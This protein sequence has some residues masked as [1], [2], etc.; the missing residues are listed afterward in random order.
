MPVLLSNT[1]PEINCS[2]FPSVQ[3]HFWLEFPELSI[4]L[5]ACSLE[6]RSL[7]VLVNLTKL[8]LV[9]HECKYWELLA[10]LLLRAPNLEV[11]ALEDV[12]KISVHLFYAPPTCSSSQSEYSEVWESPKFLPNCLSSH[13]KTISITGF[14]GRPIER[15]AAKYLLW[16]GH[17]LNK[18]TIY[19]HRRLFCKKEELLKE[20]LKFHR[21]MTC[22]V[23]FIEMKV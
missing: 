4:S 10:E 16:N 21:A 5:S 3:F 20:F 8:K 17:L 13:L 11:L 14:K 19:T 9:L 18:M 7:P 15:E 12:S 2:C 1:F 23:E 6:A 22:Q